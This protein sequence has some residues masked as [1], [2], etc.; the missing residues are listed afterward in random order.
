MSR[1]QSCDSDFLIE[2]HGH[3]K[4]LSY[5]AVPSMN[6]EHDGYFPYIQ[7][8][9]GGDD[10]SVT[11]CVTCGQTQGTWPRETDVREAIQEQL[12]EYGDD[13]DDE[14]AWEAEHD[15]ELRESRDQRDHILDRL[16]YMNTNLINVER[17]LANESAEAD[18]D[19]TY[20]L[21]EIQTWLKDQN[22]VP[23]F[24]MERGGCGAIV[25]QTEQER[26][27]F[28]GVWMKISQKTG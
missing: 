6:Y 14:D 26:D 24:D 20:L 19:S 5:T 9:C 21:D 22:I 7:G 12:G 18:F 10:I 28:A 23:E 8:L 15:R 17:V 16:C 3:S 2:L 1:C 4:D 11:I 25:F 27:K 13:D